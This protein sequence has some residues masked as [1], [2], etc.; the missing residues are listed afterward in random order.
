MP[1]DT[2]SLFASVIQ[3]TWVR[4]RNAAL[5][6]CRSSGLPDDPFE[7]HPLFKTGAGGSRTRSTALRTIVDGSR[8]AQWPA[9]SGRVPEEP[10]G[11][12][13]NAEPDSEKRSGRARATS[14]WER[15]RAKPADTLGS[16]RAED[17]RPLFGDQPGAIEKLASASWPAGSTR[18]TRGHRTEGRRRWPGSSGTSGARHARDRARPSRELCSFASSSTTPS[19]VLRLLLR[20]HQ[21]EACVPRPTSTSRRTARATTTS[22]ACGARPRTSSRRDVV[23]VASVSCIYGLARGEYGRRSC[24]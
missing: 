3:G 2:A 13:E 6:R 11:R 24:S 22:T 23:I 5:G 1:V 14:D 16:M 20:L 8:L 7:N 9:A 18:H 10:A 21:P 12:R 15:H 17:G 4:R 19:R